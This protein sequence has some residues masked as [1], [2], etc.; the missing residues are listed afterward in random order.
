MLIRISIVQ[1]VSE[2]SNQDFFNLCPNNRNGDSRH[3]WILNIFSILEP[4][5]FALGN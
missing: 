1:S 3:D 4:K 2:M 5:L